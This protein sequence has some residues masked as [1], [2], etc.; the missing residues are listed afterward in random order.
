MSNG[1]AGMVL[2]L[3]IHRLMGTGL[4]IVN[5]IGN[6]VATLV[7]SAWER[8]LDRSKLNAEMLHRRVG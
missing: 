7:I 1:A 2:I 4:A 3:G 6:G 5:T 8:E